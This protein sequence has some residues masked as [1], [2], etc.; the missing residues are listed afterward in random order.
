MKFVYFSRTEILSPFLKDSYLISEHRS[1]ETMMKHAVKALLSG[2]RVKVCVRID[3]GDEF[4][5]APH[6][7]L[8]LP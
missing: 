2:K 5:F 7:E 1:R 8:L 4:W 6:C 3:G